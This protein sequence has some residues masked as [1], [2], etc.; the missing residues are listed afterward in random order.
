VYQNSDQVRLKKMQFFL[1]LIESRGHKYLSGDYQTKN[2]HLSI[3]CPKHGPFETNFDNYRRSKVGCKYCGRNLVSKALTGRQYSED[4]ISLMSLA[5]RNRPRKIREDSEWRSTQEYRDWRK[6]VRES[7]GHSCAI[8]G[9]KGTLDSHHIFTGS[10]WK[11]WKYSPENGI[12]LSR[13]AHW[14]FHKYFGSKRNDLEQLITFT[15]ML[16]SSQA[17]LENWEGSETRSYDSDRIMRTQERLAQLRPK[18][19]MI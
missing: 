16:I 9:T 12:L 4:T 14:T 17:Q 18:L 10:V 13:A 1:N 5:A 8:T 6:A 11:E 15:D 19:V 2:S 3:H 7:W